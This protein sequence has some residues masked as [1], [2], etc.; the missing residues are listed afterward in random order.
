MLVDVP[1]AKLRQPRVKGIVRVPALGDQ[2]FWGAVSY[3]A[4]ELDP[5]SE[6]H[7]N[8]SP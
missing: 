1:E 6:S 3:T 8:G 7:A 5:A 2:V 4:P